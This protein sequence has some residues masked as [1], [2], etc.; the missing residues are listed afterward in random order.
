M[1]TKIFQ[2]T[3][4]WC[5]MLCLTSCHDTFDEG[6]PMPPEISVA[7][8]VTTDQLTFSFDVI[9][10][11]GRFTVEVQK[12]NDMPSPSIAIQGK[13]VTIDLISEH[14]SVVITDETGLPRY[15]NIHSTHTDLQLTSHIIYQSYGATTRYPNIKF[16]TGNLK[17]L[18]Q[19]TQAGVAH[20]DIDKHGAL[21][22]RA[23]KSGKCYFKISDD[24]GITQNVTVHVN[25][26]WDVTGALLE[27]E[28]KPQTRL[29]FS[30]PYGTG[31]WKLVSATIQSPLNVL[32]HKGTDG[33]TSYHH[34]WLQLSIPEG[35]KGQQVYVLKDQSGLE[36]TIKVNVKE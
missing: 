4:L 20:A 30:I 32:F 10:H 9:K 31:G 34:D 7:E 17:I 1:H 8:N 28:S 13:H 25:K 35:T 33:N 26:G 14:T 2:L 27:V 3:F 16:G 22:I 15:V 11:K 24:R 5:A 23:I 6:E 29:H 19:N 18:S 12:D 21:V 36:A